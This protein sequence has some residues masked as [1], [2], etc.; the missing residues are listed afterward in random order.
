MTALQYSHGVCVFDDVLS[1]TPDLLGR[2]E[3]VARVGRV[4]LY[5]SVMTSDFSSSR[6]RVVH[7]GV[8]AA[9][10]RSERNSIWCAA[11]YV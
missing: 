10:S 8:G 7:K 1:Q 6:V 3:V 2:L 11:L 5:V 9:L 4:Y